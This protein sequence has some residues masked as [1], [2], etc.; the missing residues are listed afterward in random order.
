MWRPDD[1]TKLSCIVDRQSSTSPKVAFRSHFRLA[2]GK[3]SKIRANAQFH[4]AFPPP[5]WGVTNC[6]T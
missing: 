3:A 2:L 4:A 6:R 1:A 5:A